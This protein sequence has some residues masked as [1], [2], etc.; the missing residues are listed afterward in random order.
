MLPTGTGRGLGAFVLAVWV[1]A[2][3]VA[4]IAIGFIR[5]VPALR[6]GGLL[7]F[8]FLVLRLFLVDLANAPTLVR[9]ALL[10]VTG[11][12]LVGVGIVYARVGRTLDGTGGV[13][14]ANDRSGSGTI[15][16]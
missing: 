6:W 8:V 3:G 13:D 11:I 10:F 14:G 7:A 15:A 16:R 4:E 1:V 9:V 2:V 5:R 12:A